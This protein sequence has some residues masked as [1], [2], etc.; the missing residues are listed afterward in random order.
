MIQEWPS[1][2]SCTT[3]LIETSELIAKGGHLNID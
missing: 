3:L 2:I 1:K